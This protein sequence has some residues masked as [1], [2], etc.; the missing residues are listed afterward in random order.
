MF[1][2]ILGGVGFLIM[3]IFPFEK[4]LIFSFILIGFSWGSILSMPYAMLSSSVSAEK[5]GLMMG[6][7]N[8]FIVIPQIFKNWRY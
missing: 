3:F 1:S 7:F 8:I 6:I 5:M 4:T 2:L